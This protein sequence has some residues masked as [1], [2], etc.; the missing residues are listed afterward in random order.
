[1]SRPSSW[2]L[3]RAGVDELDAIMA[4]ERS[5]FARD[6]W[7]RQAMRAELASPSRYYLVAIPVQGGAAPDAA[8]GPEAAAQS[9]AQQAGQSAAAQPEALHGYAGLAVAGA[10]GDIQTI[11][12]IPEMRG[13][14]L[15]RVLMQQL[16][17]EARQRGAAEVFLEVR[18]D[19]PAAGGLYE[20]LG[21]EAIAVRP[22]YYQPDDV[23]AIVMRLELGEPEAALAGSGAAPTAPDGGLGSVPGEEHPDG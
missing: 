17:A 9:A 3:R 18:A 15:G 12:V 8:A 20:R 22:R 19:N 7:S 1:M 13:H 6:A 14:G 4:I 21:F 11:A 23:D 10:Q 2:Y 16:L 5:V